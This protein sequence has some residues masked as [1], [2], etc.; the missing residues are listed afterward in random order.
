MLDYY[1]PLTPSPDA[2]TILSQWTVDSLPESVSEESPLPSA[3]YTRLP[4]DDALAGF[5]QLGAREAPDSSAWVVSGTLTASG[6]PLMAAA[7]GLPLQIPS[8]WYEIGLYCIETS[9]RCPYNVTGLSLP[10]LPTVI[11]GHNDAIAWTITG[12]SI[13]EQDISI[14]RLNPKNP[15]Q[16]AWEDGWHAMTIIDDALI[17]NGVEEPEPFTIY[18]TH[19]GPVIAAPSPLLGRDQALIVQWTAQDDPH[20]PIDALLHLNRAQNWDDFRDALEL[21]SG[22]A[23]N[24][25]YADRLGNIGYQLAGKIPVRAHAHSGMVPV[26]VEDA[27]WPDYLPFDELPSLYN[28]LQGYIIAANNPIVPPD[29]S[30]VALGDD[31]GYRAARIEDRLRSNNAH[32]ADTFAA[33]QGDVTSTFARKMLLYLLDLED[34][35]LADMQSWLADWDYQFTMDSPQAALF[36]VFWSRLLEFTYADDLGVIP[37]DCTSTRQGMSTLLAE[38]NHPWWDDVQTRSVV[39]RRDAILRKAF[40]QAII[41]LSRESGSNRDEWRWGDLHTA[42]FTS[43]PTNQIDTN[44]I[45]SRFDRGPVPVSGSADTINATRSDHRFEV[46]SA[47]SARLIIDLD[48][49]EASRA[50]LTTGQS[51]HLASSHYDDMIDPWRF[52][53]YHAMLWERTSIEEASDAMLSLEPNYQ[54]EA[55]PTPTVE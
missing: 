50:M 54:L 34:D 36:G 20:D 44:L 39:E 19:L 45:Q 7:P 12:A 3:D 33:I 24:V 27:I 25:L 11:M 41:D 23:S 10:G 47:P 35:S 22:A 18:R 29:S 4:L 13:D 2:P 46:I 17:I 5:D 43:L 26:A 52:I 32:T 28:P 53:E 6:Q 38:P 31:A 16:Y 14:A 40:E 49:F 21:W 30:P 42:S 48:N 8:A 55:T 9:P 37:C 15:A 1:S 51:S